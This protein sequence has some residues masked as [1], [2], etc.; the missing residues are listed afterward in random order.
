MPHALRACRN[1][2]TC[3]Q[4]GCRNRTGHL[5]YVCEASRGFASNWWAHAPL[6]G[7]ACHKFLVMRARGS[8]A[9]CNVTVGDVMKSR[10]SFLTFGSR[11][12]K[13]AAR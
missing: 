10:N 8:H 13:A 3:G 12:V 1:A 7:G 9:S 2:S 4:H 5:A 11:L 6:L